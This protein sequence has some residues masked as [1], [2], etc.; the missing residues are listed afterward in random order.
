M[1][2]KI[3][4]IAIIFSFALPAFAQNELNAFKYIIIPRKY[5][6]SKIENEYR[7][8]T[9]TKHLFDKAGYLT[10]VQGNDYPEEV[11]ANPCIAVTA[12][13]VNESSMFTTKVKIELKNCYDQVVYTSEEGTSKIKE[14]DKTYRDAIEK[15]FVSIQELDYTYD[16]NLLINQSPSEQ[17]KAAIVP[18]ASAEKQVEKQV[19]KPVEEPV[20][21]VPAT[22]QKTALEPMEPVT[23]NKTVPVAVAAVAVEPKETSTEK[24][25]QPESTTIETPQEPA[26]TGF[27]TAKS[28]KN[29]NISFFLIEQNN[30]LVAYVI[31]SKND[32]YK[33]GQTI[34]TFEK[35][36]LP[37]VYRVAWKKKEQDI[38]ET[39]AY[40]DEKGNLKIDIHREGKIEVLTFTEEK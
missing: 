25:Q 14:Y 18:V 26:T 2:R 40:F 22:D 7:L 23:S 10:L 8:N 3:T 34:G 15:S 1:F 35:T 31:D 16:P 17:S 5:D 20:A 33:K 12:N 29:D 30:V 37:N 28:Y 6:F 4:L 24:V 38:D 13:V 9:L 27:T 11:N 36:S 21:T 32:N 19:E 39:T